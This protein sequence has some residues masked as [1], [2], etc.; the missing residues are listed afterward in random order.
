MATVNQEVSV[1]AWTPINMWAM[2]RALINNGCPLLTINGILFPITNGVNGTFVGQAGRG[3]LL[4]DY[5]NGLLYQNIGTIFN[6]SW[7]TILENPPVTGGTTQTLPY[8][9]TQLTTNG[10]LPVITATYVITKN[11]PLADTLPAPIAGAISAG[12]QDGTNIIITSSTGYEHV[13]SAI[14][15]LMTG[16]AAMNYITFPPYPG[17]E[18]DLM[19]FGGKWIVLNAQAVGFQ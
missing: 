8:L 10:I 4:I 5:A 14:G 12:G 13:I 1:S 16:T 15:L 2:L 7:S 9:P 11:G 18:V 19:A 6:V 17:G 3:S